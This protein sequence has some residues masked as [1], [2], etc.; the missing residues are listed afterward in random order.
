MI[1]LAY[2]RMWKYRFLK[3]FY[4]ISILNGNPRYNDYFRS[5]ISQ[6]MAT[7]NAVFLIQNQFAKPVSFSATKRPE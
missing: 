6:Q 3:F 4:S 7:Y 1:N 2:R 5:R